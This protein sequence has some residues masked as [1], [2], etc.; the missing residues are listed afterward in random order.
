MEVSPETVLGFT[1]ATPDFLWSIRAN[2]YGIDFIYFRIR[3]LDSGTVLVEVSREENEEEV[4][5]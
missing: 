3:D 4:E 1:E 2:V 5:A